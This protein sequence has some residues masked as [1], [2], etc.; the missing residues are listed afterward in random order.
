MDI[1]TISPSDQ[2]EPRSAPEPRRAG[3]TTP[4]SVGLLERTIESARESLKTQQAADGHWVFEL[5]ADATIPSEYIM[6]EHFIDDIDPVVEEK[7]ARYLRSIQGEHGGWPLYHRGDFDISATVKAYLALKLV[8]D[9]VDAPHMARAREAILARG[10]AA[11]SNVFT[12]IGLALFG[13]VPWTAVPVMP[14]EMMLLPRWFPFHL[15]KVSYWTRSVLVPLLVLMSKKPTARNP[16]RVS[17]AELFITPPFEERHYMVNPTGRWLGAA[18]LRLDRIVRAAEPYFPPRRRQR[19]V[20]KA[21]AFVR[22]RLNGEDGL[23]GIFP[24]MANSVMA[25]QT[26]GVPPDH[27][28]YAIAM[29]AIRKL[30]VDHGDSAYCQPCVSPIWDTGL[31]LHALLEAGESNNSPCVAGAVDWLLKRQVLEVKGDWAARRP[32]LRPGGWAF[33]YWNDHYPDTDDTAA[34]AMA[35]QRTEDPRCREA[36]DRALEWTLGMQSENGGWGAF[37]ADNTHHY[38]N[39]IPFADHGALLDPPTSDVTARCLGFLMQM[40]L[41]RGHPAVARA[42]DFLKKEQE[43]DGSWFGRWGTNYVY[44]TWSVLS[45]LNVA[46]EDLQAPYI[47]RAVEWL[48]ARQQPDGGWGEDCASYWAEHRDEPPRSSTPSQ[49]A[50]ALLALMAAGEVKSESVARG[51]DYLLRAPRT[52]AKWH[53]ELYNAVGFPRVFF[54]RYHGY[55]AFFP[56]WALARYRNLRAGNRLTTAHGI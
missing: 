13:Q 22:E 54:L 15:T 14:I 32:N 45:A 5:E 48:R 3:G 20:D 28:E 7:L 25:F 27:P 12:R 29:K 16:R 26:L 17:V 30:V 49:T 11:R 23:G 31:A 40:G 42:L 18:F 39:H 36:L 38:L 52:G 9:D 10:G 41:G 33:Q 24:A 2:P 43:A 53:E 1:S 37:D 55:S 6:L 8:G 21:M 4:I 19:A 56:L 46:G 35:L 44:G 50:W 47:R 34:V 51:V